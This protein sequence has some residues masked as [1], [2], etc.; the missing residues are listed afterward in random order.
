MQFCK[1]L[2]NIYVLFD[3]IKNDIHFQ[4]FTGKL[5][6]KFAVIWEMVDWERKEDFVELVLYAEK[7]WKIWGI[8]IRVVKYSVCGT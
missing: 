2:S 7:E 1:V 3:W 6:L 4:F 5:L 8:N